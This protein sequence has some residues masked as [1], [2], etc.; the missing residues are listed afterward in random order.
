MVILLA[1]TLIPLSNYSIAQLTTQYDNISISPIKNLSN[2]EAVSRFVKIASSDSNVYVAWESEIFKQKNGA[3][4]LKNVFLRKG[5]DYGESFSDIIK[6]VRVDSTV[7]SQWVNLA[8]SLSNVYVTWING[9]NHIDSKD[10]ESRRENSDLFFR[11][12]SACAETEFSEQVNISNSA[13]TNVL[14]LPQLQAQGG[15]IYLVWSESHED[16]TDLFLKRSKDNGQTFGDKINLTKETGSKEIQEMLYDT[17]AYLSDFYVVWTDYDEEGNKHLYL[18]RSIDFGETFEDAITIRT[19]PADIVGGIDDPKV[20]ASNDKVY[21]VWRDNN[22]PAHN[23]AI[24][25]RAITD[26]G[27]NIQDTI[28]LSY[29][30]RDSDSPRIAVYENNV[31]VAWEDHTDPGNP[32][33]FLRASNDGGRTFSEA[34]NLS[35]SDGESRQPEIAASHNNVYVVWREQTNANA[36]ILLAFST[37]NG[38]NF[39][40]INLSDDPGYSSSPQIVAEQSAGRTYVVWE[41]ATPGNFDIFFRVITDN[42]HPLIRAP[43]LG[44]GLIITEV[45]LDPP[46]SGK[47]GQWIEILNPTNNTISAGGLRIV[48]PECPHPSF[49]LTSIEL[50]PSEYRVIEVWEK[51]YLG[52]GFPKENTTLSLWVNKELFRTEALTDTFAD[53]RTWQF[54]GAQWVFTEETPSKAIPEFPIILMALVLSFAGLIFAS[55]FVSRF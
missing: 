19:V 46:A 8:A 35:N 12:N 30:S 18:K 1:G 9:S 34:I 22:T 44:E 31:Y 49:F 51:E 17:V 45:E 5:M 11:F 32:E 37:N 16:G 43:T 36:D 27:R 25:F 2:D 55:R 41:D 33:I 4:T 21:V 10:T 15:F 6:L 29:L 26:Y 14:P 3:F 52:E 42:N 38:S 48:Q 54:D 7:G 24:F 28:T 39:R 47:L 40:T 53:S 23:F 13:S 50:Q 20:I